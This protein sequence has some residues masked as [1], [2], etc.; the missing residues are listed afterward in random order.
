MSF[1]P[2]GPPLPP[3][4]QAPAGYGGQEPPPR[5]N[6]VVLGV[7]IGVLVFAVAAAGVGGWLLVRES[8]KDDSSS[9]SEPLTPSTEPSPSESDPAPTTDPA[10]AEFY[11]QELDWRECDDYQCA[12]L[13]VPLDYEKP[14][15]AEIEI[16]VLK[17]PAR[18]TSDRLGALVVNPGGPGGSGVDFA[19]AGASQFG[20]ELTRVYDIVGFDPRG[21][22]LSNPL[23]CGTTAQLDELMAFDPDPDTPAEVAE[24]DR[25]FREFGRRCL[26]ES[27]AI[28]RHISTK[29]AAHD[30][31]VL[32]AALGESK[33][34]Y[35]GSSYGTFLGATY[36]EEFPERVGRF[37]LDAAID[38]SLSTVE[39]SLQQAHGFEIALRAYV[40]DC[41]EGGDCFLGATVDAGIARIQELLDQL[42]AQPLPGDGERQLTEG[43]GIMGV[44]M[45]LYVKEYWRAL[46]EALKSAFDGNG[47]GLLQLADIQTSRT[48]DGYDGNLIEALNAVNCLDHGDFMTSADATRLGARFE[49][50]SPT[51]GRAFAYGAS[52]CAVWPVKS[53]E[54]TTALSATGAPPIVVIGTTRD[55]ATPLIWAQAMAS[56]LD[57]GRL[58]TRD[59][60]GHTGFQRGSE[61]VDDAVERFLISGKVPKPDLQCS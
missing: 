3:L 53:G 1:T 48:D 25:L 33:L 61:C 55:P 29:E 8:T 56:Q 60:D 32:R 12:D 44:Y 38:P 28:T 24:M 21:V 59:G 52:I 31:D 17:D 50:A 11:D 15:G 34:D 54:K 6:V 5:R 18:D 22:G 30:M 27:G 19:T 2:P 36:A 13:R 40:A 43:L 14:A 10:L 47:Y 9:A 49:K 45:P 42:D 46:T 20:S 23:K 16:A 4:P 58:I 35:L 26:D 51:F 39:L 7:L 37:V 57:S 41:V